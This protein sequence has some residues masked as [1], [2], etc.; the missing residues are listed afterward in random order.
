M[1]AHPLSIYSP[2]NQ[3]PIWGYVFLAGCVYLIFKKDKSNLAL[4]QVSNPLVEENPSRKKRFYKEL[5]EEF[6][7]LGKYI[8]T[9]LEEIG[10]YQRGFADNTVLAQIKE[11][12][13]GTVQ[14]AAEIYH[15]PQQ[16]THVL[17]I[18]RAMHVYENLYRINNKIEEIFEEKLPSTERM[19]KIYNKLIKDM[20]KIV[21]EATMQG[22]E[23]F[24]ILEHNTVKNFFHSREIEH[25]FSNAKANNISE[26]LNYDISNFYS[27]R[28]LVNTLDQIEKT[29]IEKQREKDAPPVKAGKVFID[30][31]GGFKWIYLDTSYCELEAGAMAH[32]GNRGGS[33]NDRILSLREYKRVKGKE[34]ELAH[35]TF[36]GKEF[37]SSEENLMDN[38]YY[39]LEEMKGFGN[40]K[41]SK[42]YHPQIMDLILDDRILYIIGG[43]YR[44]EN[45][46][47]LDDLSDKNTETLKRQKPHFFD[48]KFFLRDEMTDKL[49]MMINSICDS[50]IWLKKDGATYIVD[51][52]DNFEHFMKVYDEGQLGFASSEPRRRYGGRSMTSDIFGFYNQYIKEDEWLFEMTNSL[53]DH[54]DSSEVVHLVES[55]EYSAKGKKVSKFLNKI[56]EEYDHDLS[57]KDIK[58]IYDNGTLAKIDER[59]WD[60]LNQAVRLGYEQ[61]SYRDMKGAF[62]NAIDG[63][64]WG[65]GLF[66]D[67]EKK[68][69]DKKLHIRITEK[70][71]AFYFKNLL[72]HGSNEEPPFS[73]DNESGYDFEN[74]Y[75]RSF[76]PSYD[77]EAALQDFLDSMKYLMKKEG[78][79]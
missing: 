69:L 29:W 33:E 20:N 26:I 41:P 8:S 13:K 14:R 28:K 57:L 54:S 38:K 62:I 31:G 48:S 22:E 71:M 4:P 49:S 16:M 24:I 45:N 50:D 53:L 78:V 19:K 21:H 51:T 17:R 55:L 40:Q 72:T 56:I 74:P 76:E 25:I 15:S 42:K 7:E 30:C 61:S 35:L 68:D 75:D 59:I 67:L 73:G 12:T 10:F 27:A 65:A 52:F 32:C 43:G 34:V 3:S 60:Y 6:D 5:F 58:N 37:A 46:F 11:I 63:L 23:G 36:I 66:I 1:I 44:P 70:N 79:K 77:D 2:K 47:S 64:D 18:Y 39:V 9:K